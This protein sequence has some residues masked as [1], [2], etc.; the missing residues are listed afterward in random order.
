[1][2]I[3]TVIFS[4]DYENCESSP[5]NQM[6]AELQAFVDDKASVGKKYT[7]KG[8]E[9]EVSKADNFEYKDPVDQSLTSKQGIRIF[10]ADGSRVV[11]RLSGTG[12]SGATVRMYVDSY[13]KDEDKTAKSSAEMLAPCVDVAL[14]ISQ[15]KKFTGREKPTV[16]T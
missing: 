4:Y 10:F 14:Q 7:G 13:E 9:Y 12:S 16:I 11:F 2:L 5:C 8:K 6:M 1:L 15:L 3:L